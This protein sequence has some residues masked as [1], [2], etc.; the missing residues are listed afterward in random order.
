M[1]DTGE[2]RASRPSIPP[3]ERAVL[4][5]QMGWEPAEPAWQYEVL[6]RLPCGI[7]DAQ[8]AEALRLSPTERL[9]RLQRLM[10]LVDEV[11]RARGDGLSQAD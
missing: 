8:L 9:E 6:D 1:R 4:S 7:D 5:R 11:M 10:D 3:G 2:G